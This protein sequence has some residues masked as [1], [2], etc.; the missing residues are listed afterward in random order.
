MKK[1]VVKIILIIGFIAGLAISLYPLVSNMY[2]KRSQMDV[3][4]EYQKEV[5]DS[6]EEKIAQEKELALTYNRKLNQTVILSDPF[7]PN[8]ISMADEQYYEILNFTNDGVMGYIKIP[9]IGVN[10][11]IYHGTDQERMLKGVGH[12]V[13]TSLPIGGVDSHA[14]LSAHSGLSS[15]DLFTNLVD[16]EK[17]DLFYIYVL[18]EVLAYEVNNIKVVKPTETDDLR[19]TKGEDYVTLVTCTPFGINSHR[20]LVRGHRVEYNPDDEKKEANKSNDDI[21]FKEYIKSIISGVG[22]IVVILVIVFVA[23]RI[24]RKVRR[25]R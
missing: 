12:L 22:V 5:A 24:T 1:R 11:P 17:G 4:N 18:D 7:D 23:K 16:L 21:W 15:A 20:L 25:K 3:I 6:D 13:G 9:R 10:L 2:A 19:I 14:V 8:A